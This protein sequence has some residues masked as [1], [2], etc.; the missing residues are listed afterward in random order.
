MIPVDADPKWRYSRWP[1]TCTALERAGIDPKTVL[2]H[3]L[4][5]S[6]YD[7]VDYFEDGARVPGFVRVP[8]PSDE[9]RDA[10]LVAWEAD[11][12]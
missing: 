1:R 8:W 3:D 12:A 10:V 2:D 11:I 5:E 6:G 9:I 4:D 7:R